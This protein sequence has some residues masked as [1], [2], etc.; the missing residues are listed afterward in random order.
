MI[1]AMA[2]TM[3]VC[4]PGIEASHAEATPAELCETEI[5][6]TADLHDEDEHQGH[7]HHAHQCGTCHFHMIRRDVLSG[8]LGPLPTQLVRLD[9]SVRFASRPP[10]SLYRPP[11]T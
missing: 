10:E 11:R 3:L 8:M 7:D 6:N 5:S 9:G 4:A 2:I 1:A